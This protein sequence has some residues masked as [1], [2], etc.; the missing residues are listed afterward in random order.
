M[1][2]GSSNNWWLP[3]PI[4]VEFTPSTEGVQLSNREQTTND[5]TIPAGAY[6]VQIRNVDKTPGSLITVNGEDLS[7]GGTWSSEER[8]DKKEGRQ[9]FVEEVV[10]VANGF[11]Y[12]W[13]ASFP[14]DGFDPTTL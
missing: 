2:H 13:K 7:Y 14:E 3:Q 4:E 10:I 6:Y 8:F 1:A 12:W 5:L 9:D 11:K